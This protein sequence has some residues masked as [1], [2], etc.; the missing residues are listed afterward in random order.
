MCQQSN[1]WLNRSPVYDLYA[2]Y[3]TGLYDLVY[4]VKSIN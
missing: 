2:T 3:I 4:N 1:V